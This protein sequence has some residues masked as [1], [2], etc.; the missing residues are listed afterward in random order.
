MV[1][2]T[3]QLHVCRFWIGSG[4]KVCE[5]ESDRPLSAG[6][7]TDAFIETKLTNMVKKMR[8]FGTLDQ[9]R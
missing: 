5:S 1:L 4:F 3:C 7:V 8:E 2:G 6:E 9:S